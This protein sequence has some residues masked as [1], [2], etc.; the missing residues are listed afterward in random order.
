MYNLGRW[1]YFSQDTAQ[2]KENINIDA[3]SYWMELTE[4]LTCLKLT[5]LRLMI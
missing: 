4:P 3:I 1:W 5:H 2:E